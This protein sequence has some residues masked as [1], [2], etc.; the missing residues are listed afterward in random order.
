M[1]SNHPSDSFAALFEQSKTPAR[2]RSLRVGDRLEGVVLKVGRD[3]IFVELDGK[4]QAY[5]DANEV[6][7]A[8]GTLTVKVGDTIAAHVVEVDGRTGNVRI[9]RSMG[10]P[11]SL[12]AIE[13]ARDTG[14][15]IEGKVTGVNKGGLEVD[16]DGTR[17]FCPISQADNKFVSDPNAFV[18]RALHFVVTDIREGGKNVLLS[19]RALLEREARDAAARLLKDLAPGAVVRGTVTGVREFGAFVDLGGVEGMI[20]ASEIS[21]DRSLSI[22]DALKAGDVVEV[23]VRELKEVTPQRQGDATVK[24]TLSLKAL[25]QDPWA[26]IDTIVSEGKVAIG[27]V[28]RLADFGAFVRL[29]SGVEGLLHVSELGGKVSHPSQTLKVGQSLA[30]VV[31]KID[32][33]GRK[34]SLVPAPEGAGVGAMVQGPS[35]GIGS[36]VQGVVERIETYGVFV[37]L[38]GLTG[39]AG[40]GLIPNA[41]L[42]TPRGSDTRKLFPEGTRVTAKVLETGEGRLRLSIRAARE[43]EE[44][45]QYDGY[46]GS[47]AAPGKLGT[48]GDLLK[49]KAR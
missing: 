16:L 24:I 39:R 42:G 32:R 45:A 17:A 18:G 20:P 8:D 22:S 33:E 38:E 25:A 2:G 34:L 49:K 26:A 28:T 12:A 14:V 40:R 44:R 48:L 15:A 10:K 47:I 29:A 37:R 31:R 23:Q 21:H 43:D 1:S 9:G 19:R 30:V 27:S 6:R 7:A 35:F 36:V 41:E 5:M 4:R 11:G 13:Q 3:A 46:R